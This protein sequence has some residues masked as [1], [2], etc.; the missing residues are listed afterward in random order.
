M[1]K[2]RT[3]LGWRSALV[4]AGGLL[5]TSPIDAEK[6][7][8]FE[9]GDKV[10]V[11]ENLQFVRITEPDVHLERA[12]RAFEKQHRSVTANEL[13]RAAAG[14]SYFAER[15]AGGQ[16][17]ELETASRALMKLADEIRGQRAVEITTLD[18]AI[19][20]AERVLERDPP[21]SA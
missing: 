18:R 5:V 14:F 8:W 17:K 15:A 16:R 7:H 3:R 4:L 1:Q 21:P 13:E 9:Q 20:D 19:R 6:K 11:R 12:R 10:Y 2:A